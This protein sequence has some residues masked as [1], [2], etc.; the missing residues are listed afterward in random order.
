MP[1]TPVRSSSQMLVMTLM[2]MATVYPIA[3][4]LILRA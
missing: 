3:L 2:T 1:K 4:W